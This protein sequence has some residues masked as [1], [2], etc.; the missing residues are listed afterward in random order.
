MVSGWLAGIVIDV[1][2]LGNHIAQL[3][4]FFLVSHVEGLVLEC[5]LIFDIGEH[6]IG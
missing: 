6:V 2:C 3:E 5:L 1:E 4:I